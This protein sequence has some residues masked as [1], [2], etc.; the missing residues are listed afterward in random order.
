MHLT[1][2]E[3]ILLHLVEFSKYAEEVEVPPGMTQDGVAR[4]AWI[5]LPH[6]AQYVRP[7]VREGLVRER[8]A[9][10]KSSPRRRKVYDLTQAGRLTAIRLRERTKSEIVR[11]QNEKG[12]HQSS[13][14]QI[15]SE[16]A[17]KISILDIVRQSIQTGIVNLAVLISAPQGLP[18]EML[19][20]AP[21]VGSFVG[22]RAELEAVTM[23]GMGPRLFVVRGVAGIGKSTFARRACELLHG[24]RNL[25]WHRVRTWDTYQSVLARLGEFLSAL[26]RPGLKS[27]LARG[28][29]SR[30][31]E[32]LRADLAGTNSFLVFDDAHETKPDVLPLLRLL[33]EVIAEASDV[34]ALVLTRRRL[35]FYNQRDLMLGSL[36]QE[37][38][39]SGLQPEEVRAL[40]ADEREAESLL[41]LS[42]RLR[43][44]PLFL[45]LARSASRSA[46]PTLSLRGV[47]AFL[48][49]E[50]YED[51]PEPHRKMIKVAS[52]YRVPV[53]REAL[54]ADRSLSYDVLLELVNR[55]LL[56]AATEDRFEVHETIREFFST[57]LTPSERNEF[58]A[59]AV[60]RLRGLAFEAAQAGA[61]VLAINYL[62]NALRVE[63][64]GEQRVALWEALGDAN[65]QIG[66]LPGGLTAYKEGVRATRD[67]EVLARMHRKM[68]SALLTRGE[69]A[70][71]SQEI[72]AGFRSMEGAF[73]VEKGWLDLLRSRVAQFSSW[74]EAREH[75][76]AALQAFQAFGGMRG[77]GEALVQLAW[78]DWHSP[79]G[80][81]PLAKDYL[82]TALDLAG[83]LGDTNFAASVH[84]NL[85]HMY[86]Y[87]LVDVDKA[88]EHVG[89]LENLPGG[90]DDP[91]IRSSLLVEKGKLSVW[92]L[93]DQR[94]A[95]SQ[96]HEAMALARKVYD[97]GTMV[98]ARFYLAHASCFRGM[99]AEARDEFEQVATAAGS[100]GNVAIQLSALWATAECSLLLGDLERF[101]RVAASFNDRELSEAARGKGFGALPVPASVVR[102]IDLLIKGD[103]QG[104]QAAL[105]E[106][107]RLAEGSFTAQEAPFLSHAEVGPFYQGLVL[108][109]IGEPE[110]ASKFLERTAELFRFYGMKAS[111][112]VM[113][114]RER[115]LTEVLRRALGGR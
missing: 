64:S 50:I 79:D 47:R 37:L 42:R 113:P 108:K 41:K 20:G 101:G 69:I 87:H 31:V 98:R 91:Q 33:K 25:F 21:Q 72:D 23:E 3:R 89:A 10:V 102:G 95:E 92:L 86:A 115:Q 52:L 56:R 68:A 32:V 14:S 109:A 57:V 17:A 11:V 46:V 44:H 114:E 105:E 104:S 111:L 78:I 90:M 70:S 29:T 63:G 67:R 34:R 30:A 12:I 7:L 24:K 106:A 4:A 73:H 66:D 84:S 59:F 58:G 80:N 71:A 2:K 13:V 18:V 107:L 49:E 8:M 53:P 77:Q 16:A 62:S 99:L 94:A 83:T 1:A 76:L 36:L 22:R 39:L 81:R 9:H 97:Q 93:N 85:I 19:S 75:G 40:A 35:P 28:E 51:L 110:R 112:S 54:F 60:E 6:L 82:L 55:S 100:L 15:L 48:E 103:R 61:Y 65:E 88:L 74:E 26:G 45:Q 96:F 5:E 38:E 27:V 43:G